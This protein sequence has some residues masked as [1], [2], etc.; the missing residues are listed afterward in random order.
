MAGTTNNQHE[1]LIT[2]TEIPRFLSIGSKPKKVREK[3]G[4][5]DRERERDGGGMRVLAGID[6]RKK[7]SKNKLSRK[8]LFS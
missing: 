5:R 4:E 8:C 3:E 7:K 6:G 1:K 2:S